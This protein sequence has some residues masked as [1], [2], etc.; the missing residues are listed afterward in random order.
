MLVW[1]TG[2][3]LLLKATLWSLGRL[4]LINLFQSLVLWLFPKMNIPV[5]NTPSQVWWAYRSSQDWGGW[6]KRIETKRCYIERPVSK[7][8]LTRVG[9]MAQQLA[10]HTIHTENPCLVPSTHVRW[11]TAA[12]NSRTVFWTLWY[13][14]ITVHKSIRMHIIGGLGAG[15]RQGFIV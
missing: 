12:C 11:L 10:V 2:Q 4:T 8:S 5:L 14:C 15:V 9:K 1:T 3:S 7:I 6:S 13:L